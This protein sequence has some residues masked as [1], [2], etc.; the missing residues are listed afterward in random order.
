M[1]DDNFLSD[2]GSLASIF[3]PAGIKEE[4][5]DDGDISFT[6]LVTAEEAKRMKKKM[7][8]Q[9]TLSSWAMLKKKMGEK[10]IKKTALKKC[11]KA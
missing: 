8:C 5:D 2:I 4:K 7:G 3:R 9:V 10:A 6:C 11:R 1:D